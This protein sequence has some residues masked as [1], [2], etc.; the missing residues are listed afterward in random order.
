MAI[1]RDAEDLIN[2]GA[3]KMGAN[4]DIDMAIKYRDIIMHYTGQGTD[5]ISSLDNAIA[6]LTATF[7]TKK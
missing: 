3:Y 6:S 5:E 7:S 4:R 2:I 1:Y